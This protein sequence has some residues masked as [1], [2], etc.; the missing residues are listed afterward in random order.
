ME[1]DN[2]VQSNNF[3]DSPDCLIIE[4]KFRGCIS[5]PSLL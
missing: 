2:A 3:L 4:A 1:K 5:S